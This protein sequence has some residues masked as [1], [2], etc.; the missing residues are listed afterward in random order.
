[1]SEQPRNTIDGFL[2]DAANK[3]F[4]GFVM[5]SDDRVSAYSYVEG[6]Q[7]PVEVFDFNGAKPKEVLAYLMNEL[8]VHTST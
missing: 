2:L 7:F 4:D 1:M 8:G 3:R 6:K 5:I